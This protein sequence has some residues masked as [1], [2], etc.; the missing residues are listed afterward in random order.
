MPEPVMPEPAAMPATGLPPVV[1]ADPPEAAS[2]PFLRDADH[3]QT[4]FRKHDG[5]RRPDSSAG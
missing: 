1:F 5:R 4:A 3:A 2:A